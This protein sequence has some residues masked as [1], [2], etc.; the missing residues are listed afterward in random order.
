MSESS[1]MAGREWCEPDRPATRAR[2]LQA[3]VYARITSVDPASTG[4]PVRLFAVGLPAILERLKVLERATSSVVYNLAPRCPFD[5]QRREREPNLRTRARGVQGHMITAPLQ[6]LSLVAAV[7]PDTWVAP[8]VQ[9]VGIVVDE[10]I[11][12]FPGPPTPDGQPTA[13]LCRDSDVVMAFCQL[14]RE[15][16]QQAVPIREAP[17]V[18]PLTERQ[19]QVAALLSRGAKDATIARRLRVST[20]TVTS[21]VGRLLDAF[22]VA[23]RWEGG[24]VM[25]RACPPALAG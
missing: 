17:G 9:G 11:G 15:T 5:P 19:L 16:Q 13:W 25:G 8:K 23:T 22:G 12:L 3:A 20:R 10:R 18:L 6:H 2:A 1:P 4:G 24:L 21:D 7:H 14:W